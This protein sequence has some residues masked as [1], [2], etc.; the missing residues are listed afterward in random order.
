[1]DYPQYMDSIELEK[2]AIKHQSSPSSSIELEHVL[3]E[4]MH[5]V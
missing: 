2:V 3:L 5:E 1:M 4:Y